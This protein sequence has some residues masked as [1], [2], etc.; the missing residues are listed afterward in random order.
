MNERRQHKYKR[1]V[2]QRYEEPQKQELNR[3]PRNKKSN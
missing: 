2:E 1:R 3:N